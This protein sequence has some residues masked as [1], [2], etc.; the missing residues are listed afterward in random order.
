MPEEPPERYEAGT[1]ST[2]AIVSLLYGV[3][4]IQNYGIREIENKIHSLTDRVCDMLS[5]LPYITLYGSKSGIASFLY[6]GY[7]SEYIAEKLNCYGICVRGGIHCAPLIH[8]R[9]GTE[10]CGLVRVSFSALNSLSDIDRLY[11]ALKAI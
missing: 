4:F 2:P 10:N 1:V 7:P 3:E 11:L 9:L 6:N 8:K 5:S